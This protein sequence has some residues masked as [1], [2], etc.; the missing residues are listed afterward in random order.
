MSTAGALPMIIGSMRF[1]MWFRSSIDAFRDW[2]GKAPSLIGLSVRSRTLLI[3][4]T[5][6]LRK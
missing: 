1:L 5:L 3:A 6:F 4:E 2:A